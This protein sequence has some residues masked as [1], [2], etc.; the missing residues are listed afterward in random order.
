M[1]SYTRGL[2]DTIIAAQNLAPSSAS[3]HVS[4]LLRAAFAVCTA[5]LLQQWMDGNVDIH[6]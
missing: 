1:L 2:F 4:Y 5:V 3:D 6:D